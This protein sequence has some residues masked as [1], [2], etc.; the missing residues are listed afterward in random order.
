MNMRMLAVAVLSIVNLAACS[1]PPPAPEVTPPP[2]TTETAAPTEI[3]KDQQGI[4]TDTQRQGLNAANQ[5]S[6]LLED[7]EAE[8]RRKLEAL[9]NQ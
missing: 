4:L 1:E 9:E 8:R 3:S 5:V 7:A 2:A 6:N